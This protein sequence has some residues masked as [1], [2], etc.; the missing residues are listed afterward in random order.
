MKNRKEYLKNINRVVIKVGSS[1]LTY[2][3]GLL[4]LYMIE[5]L[6]RQIAD[7]HNMGME[8][9]LV[10][11]AAIGAGIGKL[12]LSRKPDSIPE[13]QA[14]AAVGQGLLMNT[15][16]KFFSEYGKTIAQ[17]LITKEDMT[18][19][20]RLSNA[21]NTF[22][23]LLS[24]GVIPIVNENDAVIVDEIKFGDNDT[25]SAMVSSLIG[26]DLLILLSDVD[27]LY[28]GNPRENPEAV[29]ISEVFDITEKI[30][31]CAGGAGSK[32]GTG[33]MTTKIKAAKIATSNGV[34]MVIAKG[35]TKDIIRSIISFDNV[36]T[37][38]V[39]RN[40]QL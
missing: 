2:K 15:Y 19:K 30:E 1:T 18:Q 3:S 17:I 40:G 24:R 25:L 31:K 21:K 36:G 26:A 20:H 27:G 7:I 9:V 39:A 10:T 5:H 13:S 6:V 28:S 38:F 8:V 14:A 33:G 22:F 29:L 37:L 34:S 16:E 12:G 23:E 32:F 35:E 4:N 11:S